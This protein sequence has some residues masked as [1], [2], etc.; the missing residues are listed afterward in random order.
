MKLVF[1]FLIFAVTFPL[2]ALCD[3]GGEVGNPGQDI[4]LEFATF[5]ADVANTIEMNFHPGANLCAQAMYV[6]L[7]ALDLLSL[8]N[9]IRFAKITAVPELTR[10]D[11][12]RQLH[13]V[14][15]NFPQDQR[16][17]VSEAAWNEP[18]LCYAKK[19]PLVLHEYLGLIGVE[20]E[21]Y[22]YSSLLA[23]WYRQSAPVEK[24]LGCPDLKN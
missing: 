24:F 17:L 11:S 15:L 8:R 23:E 13:F 16:I 10:E 2:Q 9:A 7:C 5:G 6:D 4:A 1:L 18:S 22:R 12:G 14:A 20:I 21:N 19:L 3:T